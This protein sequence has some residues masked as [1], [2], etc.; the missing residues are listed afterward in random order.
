MQVIFS[1][2]M[3]S[4][5]WGSKI[6]QLASTAKQLG[7]TVDSIDYQDTMDPDLRV[8]RLCQR[9]SNED[10]QQTILVGS[11]MGGFVALQS[12]ARFA[13]RACFVLAPAIYMPGYEHRAPQQALPNLAIVHGWRDDIIPVDHSIRFAT[14]QRCEL[15]LVDDDHRLITSLA[16][17]DRWFAQFLERQLS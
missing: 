8:E 6:Q 5:P 7:C 2:G 15:H 10:P 13:V 3:E 11:S 9:L 14:E 4:G 16:Q 12:A 17:I 1:H